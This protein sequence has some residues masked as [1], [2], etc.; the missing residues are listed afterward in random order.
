MSVSGVAIVGAGAFGL[1]HATAID[2]HPALQLRAVVGSTNESAAGLADRFGVRSGRLDDVLA[3]PSID[4]VIIA[5]PHATHLD[6]A[7]RTLEADKHVLVEKPLALTTAE[8]DVLLAAEKTSGGRGMVGH[9]MRWA[10]AHQLAR[11]V[12]DQGTLGDVIAAESRRILPWNWADRRPWHRSSAQGGGMWMVQG[13]HVLDQLSW[14]LQALPDRIVGLAETR[15]H[16]D[17][18]AD[19]YGTAFVSFGA[20]PV[21]VTLAGIRQGATEIYTQIT[22]T[23]ATMRVSHRG[24][25][26]VDTGD[27]WEQHAGQTEDQWERTL[28]GELDAFA[29]MITGGPPEP[30]FTY[31]RHIVATVEAVRRSQRSGS[32]EDIG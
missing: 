31:G 12:L 32:W 4:G 18:D 30:D 22:G 1:T 15:F 7:R 13:V 3:D 2:A 28:R 6:L 14:L 8:C 25:L 29:D 9:L 20:V 5:T 21:S 16:P 10:P 24:D 23:Q 19:D 17:Q 27:G 11:H 26:V